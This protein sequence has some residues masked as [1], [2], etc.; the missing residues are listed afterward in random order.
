M[1][2]IYSKKDKKARR[3]RKSSCYHL[4]YMDF[5]DVSFGCFFP[6]SA[7]NSIITPSYLEINRKKV[8][9]DYD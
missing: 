5:R 8:I 6:F 9:E 2:L 4:V 3:K 7:I 1:H